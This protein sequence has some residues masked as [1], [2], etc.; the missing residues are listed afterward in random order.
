MNL[1]RASSVCPNDQKA[2]DKTQGRDT[3]QSVKNFRLESISHAAK[4]GKG[5][6]RHRVKA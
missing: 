1:F 4:A 5:D 6:T 2:D 3:G